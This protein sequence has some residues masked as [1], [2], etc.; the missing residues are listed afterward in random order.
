MKK[1]LSLVLA[2]VMTMSL[3]TISA[4]AKDFSDAD[5]INYDE[6]VEVLTA[7]GV[8]DGYTDDSFKPG[9][10][11]NRG[12]A[13]KIVCNLI[14]GSTTAADLSADTQLFSDVPVD[15]T[16]AAYIA[17]CVEE[18]IVSGYAD[19]SFKPAAPLTHYAFLKMLLGALGYDSETEGYIGDNWSINVAKRAL[20]IGL[21]N[22]LKGDFNGFDT[23]TREVACLYALNTLKATMVE[24]ESKLVVNVGDAQV[25]LSG[26]VDEV[27]WGEATKNDGNIEDDGFVQFA[28]KHFPKLELDT[29][30]G[31]YGRP[32]NEW[33]NAKKEIGSYASVEAAYIY[34]E[35]TKVKDVYGDLGKE[36]IEDYV[37]TVYVN[38][39]DVDADNDED[40]ASNIVL[41]N[42]KTSK[43]EWV[44]TGEGTVTEIYIK[45]ETDTAA[46][47][48]IVVEY[49]HYLGQVTKVKSDDDGEYITVNAISEAPTLKDRT[50]YVEGYEED[51]YV[52]FTI[53]ENDEEKAVIGEV[54]APETVTV[55]VTRVQTNDDTGATYLRADGEKYTYAEDFDKADKPAYEAEHQDHMVYDLDEANEPAH[56]TL[57]KD[58]VL[59]LDPN[60]YVLGFEKSE[61]KASQYLYVKDSDEEMGNWS[62]KVLL[63][64]GTTEI[65]EIEEDEDEF[66]IFWNPGTENYDKDQD[67]NIDNL[68]FKY[69]V[70]EKGKYELEPID[71]ED[72]ADGIVVVDNEEE[73]AEEQDVMDPAD[74]KAGKAYI[75]DGV[76][77]VIVDKKTVF[78]DDEGETAYIGYKEVPNIDGAEIAFVVEGRIVTIAFVLDGEKYDTDSTYFMLS[79]DDRESL[80]YDSKLYWEYEDAYVN[81]E[82]QPI[83]VQYNSIKT[84]ETTKDELEV[85]KLYKVKK[86]VD[87]D[88]IVEIEVVDLTDEDIFLGAEPIV[89]D[90]AFWLDVDDE[91]GEVKFDTDENTIYVYVEYDE[92]D[93]EWTISEG[94]LKDMK[95]DDVFGVAVIESDDEYAELV[96]IYAWVAKEGSTVTPPNLTSM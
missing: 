42:S 48:V 85:A 5:A 74:V 47:E 14:L 10:A 49:N 80:K 65:V 25:N 59:Y 2:L 55:E 57:N 16:F 17:F 19:G 34:T 62:A 4:G 24:Y 69:T 82:K 56:P 66:D 64:D 30:N 79:S 93:D 13:A 96:Y 23:V 18:G 94:N 54:F 3:V 61:E 50:F 44:Y 41:P 26:N 83:I 28:E 37:W 84:N 90:E 1:F 36:I 67:S 43:N 75:T 7:I 86:T 78:V 68:I 53:D 9:N 21:T 46:G 89:G 77:K 22:G 20:A 8:V 40:D 29:D 6:A 87:E 58:Y 72:P 11:L 33:K 39:V 38:G 31:I 15:H 91:R 88:Y 35:A 73:D 12:Q 27:R 76:N 32:T 45:D 71:E 52:V 63:A 60:G 70:T 51:D 95:D 81:G 92:E